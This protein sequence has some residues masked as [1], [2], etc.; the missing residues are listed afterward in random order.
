[1]DLS[2]GLDRDTWNLEVALTN[3]GDVIG[4]TIRTSECTPTVC[5]QTYVR[6]LRPRTLSIKFGQKF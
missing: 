3:A 6:P 5:R 1:M 4:E 2:A